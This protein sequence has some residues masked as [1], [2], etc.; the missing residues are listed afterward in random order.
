[1]LDILNRYIHGYTAMPV[2]LACYKRG[3]FQQLTRNGPLTLEQLSQYARASEGHLQI[4]LRMFESMGWVNKSNLGVYD[5]VISSDSY[6]VLKDIPEKILTLYQIPAHQL[7]KKYRYRKKL[8]KWLE[9]V[10][11]YKN[12]KN[13]VI[14]DFLHGV[15]I[16]PLLI[17]L[18]KQN[19]PKSLFKGLSKGLRGEIFEL[20]IKKQ[21]IENNIKTIVLTDA[22]RF[23]LDRSFNMAVAASHAPLLSQMTTL[24]FGDSRQVFKKDFYGHESHVDRTLNV[25]GSGFQHARYFDDVSDIII[26]IF[27]KMPYENQPKYIIDTGCGDGGL[28]KKVYEI[29]QTK[30]ARGRV[31]NQFPLYMIGVDYNKK[32]LTETEKNL[33]NI[34]HFTLQGDIGNPDAI[35][36]DLQ[37]KGIVD[38]E[39]S[40]HIR[41]FLDHDRPYIAPTNKMQV[42]ERSRI[43]YNGTYVDAKG[44]V[45]Q[46]SEMV[47]SLVEHLSRWSSIISKHG[48]LLLEVHSLTTDMVSVYFNESESFHF[49]ALQA[50]TKQY[51]VE[52]TCS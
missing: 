19:S 37:L 51:L 2:I 23:M 39:N 18:K 6:Q 13:T 12:D 50:F 17:A 14:S 5:I 32:S 4:A 38:Y 29:I 26:S 8:Q 52:A 44:K 11:N 43:S 1:M 20:F 3:I 31:L 48:L 9:F 34:P 22:G 15:V 33:R 40:L 7:L 10:N 25:I 21:W 16:V 42:Q 45:I 46:S 36:K 24:L 47:Q 35:V 30:T 41:S 27:N 49:D 28:L